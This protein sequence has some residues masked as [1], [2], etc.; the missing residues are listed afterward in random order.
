MGMR[1][2]VPWNSPPMY[3]RVR[4][5]VRASG[6]GPSRLALEVVPFPLATYRVRPSRATRTE[7][8]YQPVGMNPGGALARGSL[9]FTTGRLLLLALATNSTEPSGESASELGVLPDG[10]RGS[11]AVPI[12]ST[13]WPAAV[14]KT[15]TV[16]RLALAT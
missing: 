2:R 4:S 5:E 3:S 6:F 16:L 8:G 13:A 9:T 15:V 7:V 10:A 1:E 12:V 14:S 11:M